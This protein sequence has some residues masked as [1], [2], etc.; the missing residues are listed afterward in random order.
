MRG[1]RVVAPFA[2]YRV[3]TDAPLMAGE[4]VGIGPDEG[5]PSGAWA[6]S[7]RFFAESLAARGRVETR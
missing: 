7:I 3:G 5:A 1:S 2:L 6:R 4:L